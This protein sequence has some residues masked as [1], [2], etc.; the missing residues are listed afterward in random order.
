MKNPKLY[1]YALDIVTQHEKTREQVIRENE[2]KSYDVLQLDMYIDEL[3]QGEVENEEDE[4]YAILTS[5]NST[6]LIKTEG[7]ESYLIDGGSY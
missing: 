3:M 7:G 6:E 5:N 4:D 2:L 1:M